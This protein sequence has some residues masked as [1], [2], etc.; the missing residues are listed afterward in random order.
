MTTRRAC[1]VGLRVTS[2]IGELYRVAFGGSSEVGAS[3][4]R[5]TMSLINVRARRKGMLYPRSCSRQG[6]RRQRTAQDVNG[7]ANCKCFAQ[8]LALSRERSQSCLSLVVLPQEALRDTE[9][10]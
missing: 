6:N 5:V 4:G 9:G 7:H 3:L 2:G 8:Y 10:D 1:R